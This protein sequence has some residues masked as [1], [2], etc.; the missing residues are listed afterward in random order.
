V[1]VASQLRRYVPATAKRPPR[2]FAEI[3]HIGTGTT[4]N[5]LCD[6][7]LRFS[8][9]NYRDILNPPARFVGRSEAAQR[10]SV[11]C[12]ALD[13]LIGKKQ[14]NVRRIS[15]VS[16]LISTS[17]RTHRKARKLFIFKRIFGSVTGARTRTLRLERATC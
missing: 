10:L 16:H 14:L 7:A 5:E 8:L 15:F 9:R 6:D 13:Y 1:Y 2:S 3:A 17:R 12:R 4:I 11:S